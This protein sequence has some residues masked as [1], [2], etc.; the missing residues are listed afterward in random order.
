MVNREMEKKMTT[1]EFEGWKAW[2]ER[3]R[4]RWVV[5]LIHNGK[6]KQDLLLHKGGETGKYLNFDRDGTLRIGSY[7]GAYPHIGEAIFTIEGQKKYANRDEALRR[8]MAAT[9]IRFL[10][11]FIGG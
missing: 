8:C 6:G 2:T 9:G 7:E 1:E 11:T 3:S 4:N 10:K 5:D